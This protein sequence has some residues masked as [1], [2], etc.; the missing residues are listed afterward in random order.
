MLA[1][2]SMYVAESACF[3]GPFRDKLTFEP[4]RILMQ[5]NEGLRAI[6]GQTAFEEISREWVVR[7]VKKGQLPF[8]PEGVGSHWSGSVQADVVAINWHERQ[9]LLG[10]C[11]LGSERIDRQIVHDMI[12]KKTPKVMQSLPE[13]W[14][15]WRV[16]YVLF[17]RGGVKSAA[18]TEL[19]RFNGVSVDLRMLDKDLTT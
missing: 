6:V 10:E 17:S 14:A 1:P 9:V 8:E 15:G 7:Q 2:G 19:Q 12:E 16:H 13:D 11:K 3:L 4:D 18:L 5:V